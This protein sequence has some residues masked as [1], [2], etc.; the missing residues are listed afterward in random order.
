MVSWFVMK[1]GLRTP[2]L[3][4]LIAPFALGNFASQNPETTA[5]DV[6]AASAMF[7]KNCVTCHQIPDI[8]FDVDRAW[9]HQV[10]DTA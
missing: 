1:Q 6:A 10:S 9:L 7:R 3:L 8:R 5:K 4:L 2:L